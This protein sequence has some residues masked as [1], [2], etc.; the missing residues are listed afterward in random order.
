MS[1][2]YASYARLRGPAI[3]EGVQCIELVSFLARE[4][5]ETSVTSVPRASPPRSLRAPVDGQIAVFGFR[6]RILPLCNQR[7]ATLLGEGVATFV[8]RDPARR[9]CFGPFSLRM[10]ART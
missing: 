9:G 10:R 4:R 1:T 3:R 5:L 8:A 6:T 2:S 7:V